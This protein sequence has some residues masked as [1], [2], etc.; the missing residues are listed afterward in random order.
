MKK[1]PTK[2]WL[3]W[4]LIPYLSIAQIS[5][6][7]LE[8]IED[9]FTK[10]AD[11]VIRSNKTV[12]TIKDYDEVQ[13]EQDR[14]ITVLNKEGWYHVDA[15]TTY[16]NHSKIK[17]VKAVIYDENGEEIETIK[18][19]KFKDEAAVP[20]GT[21]YSDNRVKVLEY[22]PRNFP[23]TVHFT[24]HKE[25][26][27]TAFLPSFKP[28]E[29]YNLAVQSS[30]FVLI[31]ESG[32]KI[33]SK[34][35]HLEDFSI[36]K[37]GMTYIA[38]NIKAVEREPFSSGLSSY[39]PSV[40]FALAHFSMAG[41]EGFNENW[42]GFGKWMYDDLYQG[43]FEIPEAV[44]EEIKSQTATMS[45]DLEKAKYVYNYMQNRSR[46]ISVQVGIGGWKPIEANEVNEKAYGDCKGLSNYTKAILEQLDITAYHAIIYGDRNLI[47][48]D[49]E[50]SSTQGN[51]MI[52]YLPEVDGQ[53]YWLECTSKT[54]PFGYIAGWTDDRDALVITENGGVIKHTTVY[55]YHE[56]K[57][58][59][60]ANIVL[61][62]DRSIS[63]DVQIQTTGYQ[64]SFRSLM[65]EYS[66]EE[67]VKSYSN[68]INGLNNLTFSGINHQ[69]DKKNI[70]YNESL[71]L[72]TEKVGA[73]MD[74]LWLVQ[75][76]FFNGGYSIPSEVKDRIFDFEIDRGYVDEDVYRFTLEEGISIKALL[77]KQLLETDFGTYELY[78]EE[79][80]SGFT[81]TRKVT[82]NKGHWSKNRYDDF[83]KF[84]EDINKLD[85]TKILLTINR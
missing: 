24:S 75:P 2:T 61:K 23:V 11:A 41:V 76:V 74:E 38:K 56:N 85:K 7:D 64:Y 60:E 9:D 32:E 59:V 72:E 36:K 62:K 43:I 16:D 57:Q 33:H 78:T 66:Q 54:N 53:E 80:N 79:T 47:D 51:H 68:M 63:A 71:H 28:L 46:Y 73:Q 82:I 4:M 22:T 15:Y 55:N 40:K 14:W 21:L 49:K 5:Y 17:D 19:S 42:E 70:R 12:L 29:N 67:L 13:I 83:R 58:I 65:Q 18:E 26:N 8:P 77:D 84:R 69:N 3:M 31:N 37:S 1:Y 20:G 48:I 10:K 39:A 34:A 81:L 6:T 30:E 45:S 25:Q 52:L 27:N 50:F 44:I 35:S